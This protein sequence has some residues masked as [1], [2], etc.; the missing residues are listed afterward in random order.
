[1]DDLQMARGAV[2]GGFNLAI[3]EPVVLQQS[4]PFPPTIITGPLQY[5]TMEGHPGLLQELKLLHP[6]EE[7]VITSGAKGAL[8]AAFYAF[9]QQGNREHLPK[10]GVAHMAPYWPS[11]KTLARLSDLNFV[12]QEIEDPLNRLFYIHCIT[13]PNNP[14]GSEQAGECDILDA[15][16]Q[17]WL[18]G[19]NGIEPKYK[20]KVVSAAKL[21]GLSGA[22]VGWLVTKDPNLAL[23]ARHYVEI[24][25]SGVSTPPQIVVA[26]ALRI[27]RLSSPR[28]CYREARVKMIRNGDYFN[29]IIGEY[30]S[31]IKGIPANG[32]GMFAYFKVKDEYNM[33]LWEAMKDAN[34]SVV[35]GL[36]CGEIYGTHFRM[37]M[38]QDN[39][40]TKQALIAIRR[41]M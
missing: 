11:Y 7:V 36:A 2:E 19:W 40:Y 37:N 38:A 6:D 32:K 22:R 26:E 33:K 14:D 18:Y 4:M 28:Q 9:K 10:D 39:E 34:V 5:P 15:V 23:L 1:M 35:S 41:G 31:D 24:T 29:D 16:Y 17:H 8:L 27:M 3:G 21:L 12:S 30:C 13:S 20:I 25:G